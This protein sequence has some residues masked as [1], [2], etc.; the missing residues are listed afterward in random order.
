MPHM[1][2]DANVDN[3]VNLYIFRISSILFIYFFLFFLLWPVRALLATSP[4]AFTGLSA[5][6]EG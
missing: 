6:G 4:K 3:F 1:T 2:V 5:M